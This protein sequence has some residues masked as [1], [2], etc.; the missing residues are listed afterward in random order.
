MYCRLDRGLSRLYQEVDKQT[1]VV[2]GML[3]QMESLMTM[4]PH[5]STL[6][7]EVNKLV[8]DLPQGKHGLQ[9]WIFSFSRDI[10]GHTIFAQIPLK[11]FYL[12]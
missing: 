6:Q 4:A 1:D 3:G 2:K 5:V 7:E 8:H 11:P 9:Q 10:K 12:K